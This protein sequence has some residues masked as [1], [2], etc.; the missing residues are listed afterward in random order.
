MC[1][2]ASS[3]AIMML[4]ISYTPDVKKKISLFQYRNLLVQ[5]TELGWQLVHVAGKEFISGMHRRTTDS[6][7][8]AQ[9]IS[10]HIHPTT[11]L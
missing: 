10:H 2:I 8:P 5:E 11:Y 4:Y 7:P 1:R 6:S 3:S 9:H